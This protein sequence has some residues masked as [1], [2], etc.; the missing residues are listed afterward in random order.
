[1]AQPSPVEES[2]QET[3]ESREACAAQRCG[4][5]N[6][7]HRS[8]GSSEAVSESIGDDGIAAQETPER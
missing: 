4:A 6:V 3:C 5:T 1:M 8:A 2:P 7:V